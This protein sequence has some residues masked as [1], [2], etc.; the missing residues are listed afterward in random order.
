MIVNMKDLNNIILED[1][2]WSLHNIYLNAVRILIRQE[3]P[4]SVITDA[5]RDFV[6]ESDVYSPSK[7][8]HQLLYSFF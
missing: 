7:Q 3:F 8:K 4:L 2:L 5:I 6:F 1:F